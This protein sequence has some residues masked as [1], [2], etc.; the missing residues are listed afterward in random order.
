V[1]VT[2]FTKLFQIARTKPGTGLPARP[3]NWLSHTEEQCDGGAI[4]AERRPAT[5]LP[6]RVTVREVLEYSLTCVII[7]FATVQAWIQEIDVAASQPSAITV[8]PKETTERGTNSKEEEDGETPP[9]STRIKNWCGGGPWNQYSRS[10]VKIWCTDLTSR[11]LRAS[12]SFRTTSRFL[13]SDSARVSSS[14][15][16][17]EIEMSYQKKDSITWET[18]AWSTLRAFWPFGP[19]KLS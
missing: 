7:P 19:L 18:L 17:S 4:S 9:V 16:V 8:D 12:Y 6:I 15:R 10:G 14:W 1:A 5:T 3:E 11:D 2:Y 13:I